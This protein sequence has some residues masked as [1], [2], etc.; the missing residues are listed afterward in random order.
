MFLGLEVV[1]LDILSWRKAVRSDPTD[2]DSGRSHGHKREQE[3]I[4]KLGVHHYLSSD[5][6]VVWSAADVM[7]AFDLTTK[8][9]CMFYAEGKKYMKRLHY[10]VV[11]NVLSLK[12]RIHLL[13]FWVIFCHL[14]LFLDTEDASETDLAKHDEDDYVEIKEQ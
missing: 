1:Q 14:S 6:H 10:W 8:W 5:A 2:M 4:P 3:G 7:H 11:P 9:C 12:N 13:E